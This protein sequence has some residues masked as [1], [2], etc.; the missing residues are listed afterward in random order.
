MVAL[1]LESEYLNWLPSTGVVALTE[2]VGLIGHGGWG[3]GRYGSWETSTVK[4]ND[5][6]LIEEL[7]G[8]GKSERLER[9]H[10]LGDEAAAWVRDNL[11]QALARF[12]NVIVLTHVPPFEESTWH[13]GG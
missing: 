7:S 1:S 10:A 11:T 4:L 9:L 3:D 8:L 5:Y 6:V 13:E 2:E 12:D